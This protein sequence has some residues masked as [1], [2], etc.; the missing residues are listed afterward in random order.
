MATKNDHK[1]VSPT[2]LTGRV[3]LVTGAGSPYGIGRSIVLA[4]AAA[5][6]DVVYA[7]D[8]NLG[9]M[10]S[11]AEAVKKLNPSCTFEGRLLDVSSEEQTIQ[12]LKEITKRHGR[13]DYYFANAGFADVRCVHITAFSL[14]D[15]FFP[16]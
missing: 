3:G 11:L 2:L 5:G 13:F 14:S 4:L 6:A 12:I 10:T 16:D 9:N 8:L 15:L 1:S 7:T